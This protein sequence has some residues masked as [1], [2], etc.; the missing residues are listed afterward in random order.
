MA[1]ISLPKFSKMTSGSIKSSALGS[2]GGG[3]GRFPKL[4]APSLKLKK[5]GFKR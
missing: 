3:L 1:R 5:F 2:L 4:K